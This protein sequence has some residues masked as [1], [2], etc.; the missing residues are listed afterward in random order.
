MSEVVQ[1]S[2]RE[3][4]AGLRCGVV[5]LHVRRIPISSGSKQEIEGSAAAIDGR[6]AVAAHSVLLEGAER[7]L[8]IWCVIAHDGEAHVMVDRVDVRFV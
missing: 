1:G 3:L 5:T 7:A 8:P 4:G 6:G 2:I